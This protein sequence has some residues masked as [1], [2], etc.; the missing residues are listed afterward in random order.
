[1]ADD[2][3]APRDLTAGV[4]LSDLDAARLIAG[5]VGAEDVLL[6]KG[7]SGVFAIGA[8]CTHS[9]APLSKGIVVGDTVRCPWHHACF[10]A[11]S[12]AALAA[13]AFQALDRWTVETRAGRVVVTGRQAHAA[14]PR[15]DT[16][17]RIVIIGAGAAGAAAADALAAMGAGS[18]VTLL[19]NERDTPYDR[20]ALSKQYLKGKLDGAELPLK[21]DDLGERGVAV[22][23]GASVSA[24]EPEA[25]QVTLSDGTVVPF[26]KLILATGAE[27]NTLRVPGAD[28]AHVHLLR[29]AADARGLLSA[30]EAGR[31]AVVIGGSFIA[32]EAG[33]ALR[34][35]GVAVTIVSQE[36]HPFRTTLGPDL[37]SAILAIHGRKG[38]V[39][40][41]GAEVSRIEP[42]AV[43]LTD[44]SSLAAD[45]VLIGIGVTPRVHLAEQAGLK[46]GDGVL[47]D[48]RLRTSDPNIYAVGDIA[49]W[50]DPHSGTAVR[51]EHWAV[52]QRQG[53]V[54]A[55]NVLGAGQ[56]Y[57][58]PPFF[59]TAHFDLSV[60]YVGHAGTGATS[61]AEGNLGAQDGLVRYHEG[62]REVAVATVGRDKANLVAEIGM[63]RR[64]GETA[65]HL[66]APV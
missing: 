57:D 30:V 8:T 3:Q 63:E 1:M 18:A 41:L 47:V 40:R 5:K 4:A 38:T 33:A 17:E 13:P 64:I 29:S 11:R 52:A 58:V 28:L 32:F 19:G 51:V 39:L 16:A 25:R 45:L 48:E 7:A 9:G 36:E 15:R 44:G 50:P 24:I 61:V 21:L 2:E 20:T 56:R 65:A 26:T 43:T 53:Q 31:S 23:L 42:H 37:A 35:Q 54:A 55:M 59:W 60:R 6:V 62:G 49:C 12:G 34:D 10:D 46:V 22:R 27:P 14:T 66:P